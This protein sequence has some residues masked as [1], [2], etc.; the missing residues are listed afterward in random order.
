M[1]TACDRHLPG[2]IMTEHTT[3]AG[4]QQRTFLI[5][6]ASKD[7]GSVRHAVDETATVITYKEFDPYGSP[8][9]NP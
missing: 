5:D 3:G 8:L 9:L 2:V 6:G 4:S 1:M 7:V